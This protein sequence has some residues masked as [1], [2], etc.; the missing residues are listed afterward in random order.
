MPRCLANLYPE[1]SEGDTRGIWEEA[2][3]NLLGER[4]TPK[5]ILHL[6]GFTLAA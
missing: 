2:H 5:L 6:D 1:M 3:A 4:P